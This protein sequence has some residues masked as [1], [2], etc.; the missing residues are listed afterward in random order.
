M[1]SPDSATSFLLS[2]R[3]ILCLE[4]AA[5]AIDWAEDGHALVIYDTK[6]LMKLV[7]E[8]GICRQ[9]RYDSFARQLRVS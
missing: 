2:F 6:A 5:S 4:S 1:T 8:S 9:D 7:V 3:Q